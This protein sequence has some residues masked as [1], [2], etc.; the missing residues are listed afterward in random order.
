MEGNPYAAIA[1]ALLSSAPDAGGGLLGGVVTKDLEH[2]GAVV[3]QGDGLPLDG[4]DLLFAYGLRRELMRGD[5]VFMARSS[6]RQTYYV[7]VRL[8]G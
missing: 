7:L 4:D 3:I 2:D 1:Q 6:D 8:E 5:R